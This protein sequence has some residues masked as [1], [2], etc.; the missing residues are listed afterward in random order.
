M[1]N[2]KKLRVGTHDDY[3]SDFEDDEDDEKKHKRAQREDLAR[4]KDQA[5]CSKTST[6]HASG[7]LMISYSI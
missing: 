6:N 2:A 7:V 4:K 1:N 5:G 3:D